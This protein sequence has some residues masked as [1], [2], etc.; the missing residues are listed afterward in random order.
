MGKNIVD[1]QAVKK[2]L[3]GIRGGFF[4]EWVLFVTSTPI[5]PRYEG[6]SQ[7]AGCYPISQSWCT[8]VELSED[9]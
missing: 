8:A 6:R 5:F 4:K 7:E 3:T 2:I 1:F 9:T